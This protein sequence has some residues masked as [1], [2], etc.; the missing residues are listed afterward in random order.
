M[1]GHEDGWRA[2]WRSGLAALLL[3]VVGCGGDTKDAETDAGA[4][5]GAE[6]TEVGDCT[7]RA[8][9]DGDG[10]FDC[11]DTGCAGSPDCEGDGDGDDEGDDVVDGDD[12]GVPAE[13]DC[14]D[15]D[16]ALGLQVDDR[17]CDGVSYADD[18]D[19][20]DGA[21]GDRAEDGD[22][23]GVLASVDCDDASS[24]RGDRGLDGDCDG[25][26]GAA[27]C[28]DEDAGVGERSTDR[29][30][31]GAI[32]L[33]DCDDLDPT[34]GDRAADWDC[35]GA[36]FEIDC[37]DYD[38]SSTT[39]DEDADCDN[40]LAEV[41][42]DD[43]DS[44]IGAIPDDADCDGE[45][46]TS[47][48]ASFARVEGG[49]FDIWCTPG[50]WDLPSGD[51]YAQCRILLPSTP[52]IQQVTLTTATW[53][54]TTEVTEAQ[55]VAAGFELPLPSDLT[56]LASVCAGGDC[57]ARYILWDTAAAFANS[58]SRLAGLPECYT[59]IG[60][61]YCA[62]TEAPTLCAGYRL[63][64]EA[65][66]EVAAR[67]GEDTLYAG[68]DDWTLVVQAGLAPVTSKLP[69][70]CGLY[71]MTGNAFEWTGD[72]FHYLTEGRMEDVTDPFYPVPNYWGWV[73]RGGGQRTGFDS[74]ISQRYVG[75]AVGGFAYGPPSYGEIGFRLVRTVIE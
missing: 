65:E 54:Q 22:C 70:R 59:C 37:D 66:Y 52:P 62:L 46:E 19:D 64:T 4:V 2:V 11:D 44:A 34:V 3:G 14:D 8:D 33:I 67:C 50:Q 55:F 71:G 6:G 74:G 53:W 43:L 73:V 69:N 30:C 42:C 35:D 5:R 40:I 10:A 32:G 9:N 21:A 1:R 23:D 16:P 13:V 24:T 25:V 29:D 51:V 28:D 26:V 47:W 31:D 45:L 7:D 17:D 48:G 49:T 56:S 68:S 18:C 41:D 36:I 12:D 15:G 58:A 27:D 60:S 39:T 38:S 61:A 57:P 75:A 63:P 20:L 72:N